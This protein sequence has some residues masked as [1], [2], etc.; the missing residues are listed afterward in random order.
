MWNA[1]QTPCT[2]SCPRNVAL[3]WEL[4]NLRK[5]ALLLG[6]VVNLHQD[7]CIS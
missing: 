7:S 3:I 6:N 4:G 5:H 1:R 2:W